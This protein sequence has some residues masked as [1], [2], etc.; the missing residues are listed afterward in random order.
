[1]Q[2][3]PFGGQNLFVDRKFLNQ[4]IL[5]T[6]ITPRNNFLQMLG[7]PVHRQT[8]SAGTETRFQFLDL[9]PANRDI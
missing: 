4:G 9:N 6:Q 3:V 5:Q 1:M 8:G 7:G 2:A